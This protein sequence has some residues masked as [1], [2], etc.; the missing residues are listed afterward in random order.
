MP[1][2]VACWRLWWDYP[3]LLDSLGYS[4]RQRGM[5]DRMRT[6]GMHMRVMEEPGRQAWSTQRNMMG[7]LSFIPRG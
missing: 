6:G 1:E 3:L 2:I 5:Q 7:M 4:L